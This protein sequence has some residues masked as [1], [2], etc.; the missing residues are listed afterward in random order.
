MGQV[1]KNVTVEDVVNDLKG[2]SGV[3]LIDGI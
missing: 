2:S 1:P 3:L